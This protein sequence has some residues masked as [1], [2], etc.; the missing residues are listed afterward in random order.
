MPVKIDTIPPVAGG[1]EGKVSVVDR[2]FDPASGTFGIRVNLPN[3]DLK[4]PAGQRC[5][6]TFADLTQ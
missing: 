4:I 1:Y 3:P 5:K 6:L 2:V